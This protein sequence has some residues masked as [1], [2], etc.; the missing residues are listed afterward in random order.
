MALQQ[1]HRKASQPAQVVAQ[2]PLACAAVVLAEVYVQH[3]VHRLDPPVA[4]HCLRE[5]LAA[6]GATAEIITHLVR[7]AT[8]GMPRDSYRA[9]DRLHPRPVLPAREI[10]RDFRHIIVPIVDA[11]VPILMRL[12]GL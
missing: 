4:S 1:R 2:S 3:P 6:E 10:T 7:L 9:A 8:I 12:V 11:A 5:A